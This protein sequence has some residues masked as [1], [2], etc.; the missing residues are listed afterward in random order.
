MYGH[1]IADGGYIV[2]GGRA[3]NTE[4]WLLKLDESGNEIWRYF[5]TDEFGSAFYSVKETSDGGFIAAGHDNDGNY[6]R[7]LLAKVDSNGNQEFSKIYYTPEAHVKFQDIAL[8][9]D[10]GYICSGQGDGGKLLLLKTDSLGNMEWKNT[11]GGGAYDNCWSVCQTGMGTYILA[12]YTDSFGAGL[13]DV[14]VIRTDEYGNEVWSATLGG[15]DRDYGTSIS[16]TNDEGFFIVGE[17][18][19]FGPGNDDIWVI[20]LDK[21]EGLNIEI[22]PYQTKVPV[23]GTLDFEIEYANYGTETDFATVTFSAYEPGGSTPAWGT[24]MADFEFTP[25]VF[26]KQYALPIPSWVPIDSGY[27][28]EAVISEGETQLAIDSFEWEVTPEMTSIP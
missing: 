27:K 23:S 5:Y 25:G 2:L 11:F 12:G 9:N 19:S 13:Q 8:T 7:G 16:I 18:E 10:S 3:T 1:Q 6:Y 20:R 21:D 28:F 15:N 4:V 17:T 14:Y 26:T 22:D 24:S